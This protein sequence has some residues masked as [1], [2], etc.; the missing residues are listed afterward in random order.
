MNAWLRSVLLALNLLAL[1]V[2]VACGPGEGGTGPVASSGRVDG[3]GSAIVEGL[4]FDDSR[5]IVD[6]EVQPGAPTAAPL[7]AIE[8]GAIVAVRGS[9]GAAERARVTP[10]LIGIVDAVLPNEDFPAE[11]RVLGQRVLL[12]GHPALSTVSDGFGWDFRTDRVAEIHGLRL[13]NGDLVATRIELRRDDDNNEAPMRLAGT[14][15]GL[16]TAT[17]RFRIGAATVN[18]G[19]A[20]ILPAGTRLADGQRV[21]VYRNTVPLLG[22]A[23]AQP[24][25]A[26]I[27]EVEASPAASGG[28]LRVAGFVTDVAS[29]TRFSVRGVR[30]DASSARV[31]NGGSA[32]LRADAL[33]RVRGDVV[34]GELRAREIELVRSAADVPIS[35]RGAISDY[36]GNT[37]SFRLRGA[38][39]MVD[40]Q[41]RFAG[42]T[43]ANL[44]NGVS[45]SVNGV[46]EEGSLRA[47]AVTL[48]DPPPVVVGVVQGYD[49]GRGTFL[50][51]PQARTIRLGPTTAF[52]GGTP[53]DLANGQRVRV[54]GSAGSASFDAT[55]VVFLDPNG[56]TATVL[57]AGTLGYSSATQLRINGKTVALDANT[58][59]SGGPTGTRADLIEDTIA[60]VRAVRT[61]SGL[62]A[63][64]IEVRPALTEETSLIG[65]VTDF[66]SP[67]QLRIAGQRVDAATAT[68]GGGTAAQLRDGLF[69]LAEGEVRGGVFVARRVELLPN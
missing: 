34:G 48:L 4:R 51:P 11:L 46:I 58:T 36:A 10:E 61:A 57:L 68:L 28:E 33:V 19:G 41:T 29:A 45:V 21:A 47:T 52:R 31:V 67:S 66:V 16:D 53:A 69:V 54:A 55:E 43:G 12:N 62:L 38:T 13:A 40:A 60:I 64:S 24:I 63:R 15:T 27:I 6:L 7:T 56:A 30:V 44:G 20:T 50:L 59:Y 17:Q 32:D 18:F 3:F 39:V 22:T 2:I 8:L 23:T 37:A 49:A 14:L 1:A 5:A 9:G 35:V 65:Y 26:Q 42:G 25:A